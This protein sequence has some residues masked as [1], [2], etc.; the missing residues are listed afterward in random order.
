MGRRAAWP[1]VL[2]GLLAAVPGEA[3]TLV[4]C[5]EGNPETLNPQVASTA[6]GTNAA[7]PVFDSLVQFKPGTTEIVPGL[8]QSWS[9]SPDGT[10]Y[11]FH[12]RPNVH[13]HAR[14]RFQPSRS[15][16]ADDVLFSFNRQWRAD[17]PFHKPADG[18]FD[19]FEDLGMS[20]LLAGIDKLDDLTVRFRLTRPEAPFITDLAMPFA[21]ILSKEYAD[22]MLKAGT[23]ER[24]D[25]EPIGT[26]PF[27]F[28][29]FHK[30][31]GLRYSVFQDYWAGRPK[32]DTL[33]FSISSD[34]AVRLNK[35]IAGECQ[36]M[37]LP[38]PRDAERIEADPKLSLL[39]QEGLNIGYLALN[40]SKPPFD[41]PRVRRAVNMAIDRSTLVRAIYGRAGTPI[42]NPLPPNLWS[43]NGAVEDYPYDPAKAQA[44][45]SEA[46][47]DQGVTTELWYM[48]I[49]RPYNPA[50][51]EMAELMASDLSRIGITVK[52]VTAEW[53]EYRA[54]IQAGVSPMALYGWIGDNGDPDNFLA[55]LLGC[56]DGHPGPNNIAKWCNVDFDRLIAQGKLVAD[57]A[58]RA[59]LYRRAQQIVHDEAAIVPIA[60]SSVL[61]AI[62]KNVHGFMIDPLG[63]YIF[64]IVD[65]DPE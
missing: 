36:V 45:M 34:P 29:S 1:T 18:K 56:H 28:E 23:P 24:L 31:V 27:E 44:L 8:A 19:Y 60:Q 5:S 9:I 35:L 17:D 58:G 25:K 50:S 46:G 39:Y 22:Q 55:I 2:I 51:R 14:E 53:S 47:L 63:R 43:Y 52:L 40:A 3:K 30:D 7:R 10:E 59:H 42:K 37:A 20:G 15:L 6:L 61:M 49:S 32:I 26:G 48:P 41:D 38:T 54:K 11:V 12:L 62:R 64:D 4:F 57:Q 16:D 13:F 33:V 65:L 21:M